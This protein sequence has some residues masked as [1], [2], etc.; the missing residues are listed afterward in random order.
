MVHLYKQMFQ[1]IG[2]TQATAA[3]YFTSAGYVT[4]SVKNGHITVI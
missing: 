4:M 2:T 3:F 1:N